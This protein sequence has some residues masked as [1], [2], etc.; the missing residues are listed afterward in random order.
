MR[1][2]CGG[3]VVVRRCGGDFMPMSRWFGAYVV[4]V[5]MRRCG[6]H[7]MPMSRWFGTFFSTILVLFIVPSSLVQ[8]KSLRQKIRRKGCSAQGCFAHDGR[9]EMLSHTDGVAGWLYSG[10]D[11]VACGILAEVR[12]IFGGVWRG[13][14]KGYG[15]FSVRVTAGSVANFRREARRRA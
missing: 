1:W 11:G 4:A 15:G 5:V 13:A 10:S 8:V 2:W 7:F 9:S 6:G 12:R 14:W 3:A